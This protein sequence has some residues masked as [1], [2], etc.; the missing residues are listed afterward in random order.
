MN[1]KSKYIL[2]KHKEVMKIKRFGSNPFELLQH[3][4]IFIT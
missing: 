1:D 3:A 4:Y 2:L